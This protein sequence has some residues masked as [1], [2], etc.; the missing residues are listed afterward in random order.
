MDL[1]QLTALVTVAG[2]GSITKA[3][4]CCTSYSRSIDAADIEFAVA[5][6]PVELGPHRRGD[7]LPALSAGGGPDLLQHLESVVRKPSA[8][9][10]SAAV[11]RLADHSQ[12]AALPPLPVGAGRC[13]AT[14]R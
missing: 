13:H 14:T 7:V 10:A 4:C 5:F 8:T 12:A 3:A 9:A 6:Q 1:K 11:T 2:V